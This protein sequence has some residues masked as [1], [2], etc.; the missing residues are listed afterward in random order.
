[1]SYKKLPAKPAVL[2][3]CRGCFTATQDGDKRVLSD[4]TLQRLLR[5]LNQYKLGNAGLNKTLL[6]KPC[7]I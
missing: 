5:H 3:Q 7:P 6:D 1:L 4:S 2:A